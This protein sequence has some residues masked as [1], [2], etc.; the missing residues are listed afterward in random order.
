M[1]I[2]RKQLIEVDPDLVQEQADSAME[3]NVGFYHPDNDA[4][5]ITKS[6]GSL[7]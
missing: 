7:I 5:Y 4:L 3:F 6:T 1:K 2:F